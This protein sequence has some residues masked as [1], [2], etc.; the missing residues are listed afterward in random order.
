MEINSL[1][2]FISVYNVKKTIQSASVYSYK[3]RECDFSWIF[4]NY[5]AT[6]INTALYLGSDFSV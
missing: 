4:K 5:L 1:H 6:K 2:E 3:S